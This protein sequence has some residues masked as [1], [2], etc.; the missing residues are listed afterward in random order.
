MGDHWIAERDDG[1]RLVETNDAEKRGCVVLDG[2]VFGELYIP[3]ILARGEWK[4][5]DVAL[6]SAEKQ[7][8]KRALARMDRDP[9]PLPA[10]LPGTKP[11]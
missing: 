2:E 6:T 8:V 4:D 9:F 1:A 5:I 11:S 3:S 7:R 10:R